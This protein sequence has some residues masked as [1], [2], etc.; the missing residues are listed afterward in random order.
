M[1]LSPINPIHTL[2]LS[3]AFVR[4]PI[5][6]SHVDF[7]VTMFCIYA[8]CNLNLCLRFENE[9]QVKTKVNNVQIR[10]Y[11]IRLEGSFWLLNFS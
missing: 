5:H 1:I 2:T 11:D 10:L 4:L 3:V 7:P 8:I 9:K 6:T